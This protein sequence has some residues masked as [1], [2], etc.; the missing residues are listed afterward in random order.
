MEDEWN[1]QREGGE[2]G[3]FSFKSGII[4]FFHKARE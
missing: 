2:E 4:N 3:N 1:G